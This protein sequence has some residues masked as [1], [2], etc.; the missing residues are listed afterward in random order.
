MPVL[1]RSHN[2]SLDPQSA[3]V[4]TY[5]LYSCQAK[6]ARLLLQWLRMPSSTKSN[7]AKLPPVLVKIPRDLR[8]LDVK[9][10]QP[11]MGVYD[12]VGKARKHVV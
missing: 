10:R 8:A 1:A 4:G 12:I 3:T 9:L 11:E 7:K 2:S 6:I 5:S